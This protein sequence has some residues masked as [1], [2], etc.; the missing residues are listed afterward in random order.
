MLDYDDEEHFDD[1][2]ED[3]NELINSE[4]QMFL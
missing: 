2:G 3:D 4:E 1:E